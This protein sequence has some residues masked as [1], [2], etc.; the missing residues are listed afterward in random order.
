MFSQIVKEKENK[1]P[2]EK[3][4]YEGVKVAQSTKY[5]ARRA[6]GITNNV[7]AKGSI[8]AGRQN[9]SCPSATRGPARPNLNQNPLLRGTYTVAYSKSSLNAATNVKKQPNTGMQ[10]SGQ[11][12]SNVGHTAIVTSNT[13]FTS[14]LNATLSVPV[15]TVSV[16]M[17]LGPM[18]KTRTGLIPA[19]TQPK[20][21]NSHLTHTSVREPDATTS[22][23]SKIPSRG[24]SV[25]VSQRSAIVQRKILSTT[26]VDKPVNARKTALSA[27]MGKV[28][29]QSHGL[30]QHSQPPCKSQLSSGIKAASVSSKCKAAPVKPEG[31][32]GMSKTN[33]SA[34]QPTDRSTRQRSERD[35]Q[36]NN[37]L[38]KV[39]SERSMSRKVSEVTRS[40]VAE[41]AGKTVKCKETQSKNRCGSAHVPS[42]QTNTKRTGF[43]VMSQTAPQPVRTISLTG[44]PTEK[45]TP[46]VQ[47]R[48]IPQTEGKKVTAAQEERM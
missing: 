9:N 38:S 6:F 17:S 40:A 18:V 24:S 43:P 1:I 44:K 22:V 19:V 3:F 4:R 2:A 32:V 45:K 48:I 37:R 5:P 47:V 34:G 31:K 29:D 12:S 16:R 28:Q 30:V 8:L 10:A 11:A 35:G 15:K 39:S 27:K 42:Q 21:T 13:R 23:T 33:Q 36:K 26:A 20:N 25:S 46:K 41:P 7:D 14:S